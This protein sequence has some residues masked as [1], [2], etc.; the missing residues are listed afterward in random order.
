MSYINRI[1]ELHF[2]V[3]KELGNIGAGNAATALSKLLNRKI[4]M[5]LP[6]ARILSFQEIMELL[7][8]N[9]NEVASVSLQIEG[10]VSG[11]MV[12]VLP[13]SQVEISVQQLM[14]NSEQ[15]LASYDTEF[16]HS[17]LQELGNILTGSYLTSLADFTNLSLI[18]TVP[19]LSIDRFGTFISEGIIEPA[20]DSDFGIVIETALKEDDSSHSETIKGYLLLIPDS[21]FFEIIFKSLGIPFD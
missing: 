16:I 19:R 12:F 13:L 7:V 14:N 8:D 4:V 21:N 11:S 5:E 10:D 18:P 6:N 9:D 17:A 1:T 3:L 2:D 15:S 20:F